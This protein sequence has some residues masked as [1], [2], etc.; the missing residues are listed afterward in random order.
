MTSTTIPVKRV[1]WD[2]VEAAQRVANSGA[3]SDD[4]IPNFRERV[5][6]AMFAHQTGVWHA[7]WLVAREAYEDGELP[8]PICEF[9][10][11]RSDVRVGFHHACAARAERGLPT[12]RLDIVDGMLCPCNQ[13]RCKAARGED[14]APRRPRSHRRQGVSR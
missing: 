6:A 10:G 4:R 5:A 9:C 2:S 1:Q 8:A 14:P 3:A 13:A 11:G 7:A 12:P